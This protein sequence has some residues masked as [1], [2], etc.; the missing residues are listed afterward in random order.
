MPLKCLICRLAGVQILGYCFNVHA[1]YKVTGINNVTVGLCIHMLPI[2]SLCPLPNMPAT[3]YTFVTLPCY[4]SLHIDP[5]LRLILSKKKKK[6]HLF[7]ISLPCICPLQICPLNTVHM[8]YVQF[9]QCASMEGYTPTCM[10][11]MNLL[12]SMVWPESPTQMTV[13]T[14]QPDCIGYIWTN[15]PKQQH[16]LLLNWQCDSNSCGI[17]MVQFLGQMV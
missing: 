8:P 11:H 17:G 1:L 5:V 16:V 6:K 3:L 13:T 7:A 4:D 14:V 12:S 9:T 10:W 15:K 2:I